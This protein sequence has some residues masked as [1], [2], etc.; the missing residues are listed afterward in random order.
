MEGTLSE[1]MK[2]MVDEEFTDILMPVNRKNTHFKNEAKKRP[3][4][5]N[6]IKKVK[7]RPRIEIK[8][9]G[10]KKPRGPQKPK[11]YHSLPHVIEFPQFKN[12]YQQ[13]EGRTVTIKEV[14]RINF[15]RVFEEIS[16][17]AENKLISARENQLLMKYALKQMRLR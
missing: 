13:L 4:P 12:F 9:A 16:K 15:H 14:D 6:N 5:R 7:I 10:G 17:L 1:E 8:K 3:Q 2:F 11:F